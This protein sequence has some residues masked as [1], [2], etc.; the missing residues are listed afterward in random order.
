MVPKST[1][2]FYSVG[3]AAGN[4]KWGW[5]KERGWAAQWEGENIF[6]N[7][8]DRNFVGIPPIPLE[9]YEPQSFDFAALRSG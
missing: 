1:E 4:E 9:T 3:I 8:F 7:G 6:C 2:P 5:G